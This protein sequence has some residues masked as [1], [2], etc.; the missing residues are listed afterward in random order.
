[1]LLNFLRAPG[2]TQAMA[3]SNLQRAAGGD[4]RGLR[5]LDRVRDQPAA[6]IR[7]DAPVHE[8][9]RADDSMAEFGADVD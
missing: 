6:G 7:R 3:A 9:V 1:M 2:Q 8:Q 5:D 4:D